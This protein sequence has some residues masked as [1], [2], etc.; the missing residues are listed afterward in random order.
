MLYVHCTSVGGFWNL[1]YLVPLTTPQ[2]SS[3]YPARGR[4]R[5]PQRRHLTLLK[6]V[7]R[8][9]ILFLLT[10]HW[11]NIRFLV[12][13][14]YKKWSGMKPKQTSPL[15]HDTSSG[16]S[17]ILC[18]LL[19]GLWTWASRCYLDHSDCLPD[20]SAVF[21]I[22]YNLDSPTNLFASHFCNHEDYWHG[23]WGPW[24]IPIVSQ[25]MSMQGVY[26]RNHSF[27]PQTTKE[28]TPVQLIYNL[29]YF[30]GKITIK[31]VY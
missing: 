3:L 29:F 26:L 4:G 31:E 15:S 21:P 7:P 24:P 25:M 11:G 18:H 2:A 16:F 19:T 1:I 27:K 9:H 23:T 28:R 12:V 13:Q 14:S 5:D 10:L 30:S 6:P 20:F 8:R 17:Y 22:T